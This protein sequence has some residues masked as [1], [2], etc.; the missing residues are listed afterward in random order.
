MARHKLAVKRLTASDLTLFE[1][2][3]R[4]RNA[5][6]QKAIN[7]N[8][9]VF[10]DRLYPVLPE[11]AGRAGRIPLDL[12]IYGPGLRGELNLQRKI[13]KFPSYKNWRLDGE[14]VSPSDHTEEPERFNVLE[15][16]D[17]ALLEFV[18]DVVPSR[19]RAVFLAR[20]VAEDRPLC[21]GLDRLLAES[22]MA[23]MSLGELERLIEESRPPE[24]HPIR[25][26]SLEAVVEDAAQGGVQSARVLLR[27]SSR[28]RM[29]RDDLQ[30]SRNNAED[31]GRAGEELVYAYLAREQHAGAISG[32]DWISDAN[33]ISPYDFLV[34]QINGQQRRIDV[35]TTSYDFD[36]PLHISM[37][38][39]LAMAEGPPYSIYR[40]YELD[41][42]T[43]KLRIALAAEPLAASVLEGFKLL[44]AGVT[45]DG[46]SVSPSIL[47]FGPVLDL[48]LEEY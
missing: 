16:G 46:V 4:N 3:F 14:C 30:R 48:T 38:E 36:R 41:A 21:A 1:W 42:A 39:L 34:T 47:T 40:V 23:T 25:D 31:V 29:S 20:G 11:A 5:G 6:N 32:F 43:A 17:F 45:P 33:A 2:H 27:R 13:I 44:P 22:S 7:L 35:K 10:I 24:G 28:R 19:A 26:L 12:F 18:G 8:A 15:P 37:N 9:D